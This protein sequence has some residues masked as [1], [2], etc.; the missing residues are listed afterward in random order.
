MIQRQVACTKCLKSLCQD[1][2]NFYS[3]PFLRPLAQAEKSFVSTHNAEET[4]RRRGNYFQRIKTGA[5]NWCKNHVT[6]K[7]NPFPDFLGRLVRI[8]TAVMKA[9]RR[10]CD[11]VIAL[12]MRQ[13]S[14]AR[15]I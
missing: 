13:L 2:E 10:G 8:E 7:I 11:T 12:Q 14:R 5:A 4:L 15:R 9:T 3:L 1:T 6:G